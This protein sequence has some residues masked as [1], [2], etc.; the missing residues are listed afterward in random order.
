MLVKNK[1][2]PDTL[3]AKPDVS[4]KEHL[5]EVYNKVKEISRYLK[6]S[7]DLYKKTLLA[8]ILH[9]IGKATISFQSY[10]RKQSKDSYP[11]ALASFPFVLLL[12][13]E[14]TMNAEF[15]EATAAVLTHHSP[16]TFKLYKGYGKPDY[17]LDKLR[18]LLVHILSFLETELDS[19][20]SP[21]LLEKLI[22][23]I[24]NE[25]TGLLDRSWSKNGHSISLRGHLQN[26]DTEKFA[27]VK[28]VLHL[29]DWIVSSGKSDLNKIFLI[30]GS[31]W[32]EKALSRYELRDFQKRSSEHTGSKVL[33]LRAPTGSGKTEALLL[34]ARHAMRI[35]YFLP[36][37]AT[38][39]AMWDRLRMIFPSEYVGISHGNANYI[40]NSHDESS[41][42]MRLFSSAFA[43]PVVVATL[44]QYLFAH[45]HGKYWE[46]KLTLSKQ[47][48][49]ILD[50]IHA[51]EPYTIGLL[52][53]A[54][55]KVPPAYYALA[56]ATLPESLLK[57]FPHNKEAVRIEAD[58]SIWE[59]KRHR[60]YL[61][62][63][64]NIIEDGVNLAIKHANMGKK[65]LV[66]LNT[67]QQAQNFYNILRKKCE[68]KGIGTT[69][70]HSRFILR[71]RYK[72]EK[73]I[74]TVKAPF[75]LVA[76]QVVEVSL[77]ISYDI[78]ITEIAP[79][80]AIIQRMGRIN[81]RGDL[82]PSSVFIYTKPTKNSIKVY[83]ENILL[84]SR[85]LLEKLPEV[86]DNRNLAD[87]TEILYQDIINSPDWQKEFERGKKTVDEIQKVLGCYTIDLTDEEMTELFKTRSGAPSIEVLPD[88]FSNQA[89]E[90]KI[91]KELWRLPEL[92]VPV[93]VWWK[94]KLPNAFTPIPDIGVFKTSLYYD[95]EMGLQFNEDEHF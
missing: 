24:Q 1:L 19:K 25:P 9:D 26:L 62:K 20:L 7:D 36:T 69:L 8:A 46:D 67:I 35:L 90:L 30:E 42:D 63:D 66:V 39:N 28:T 56:S 29:A 44:D 82:P 27:S 32:V 95:S 64:G 2:F 3:L 84:K 77:D 45:L 37:Q 53:R 78:L 70:L 4:L 33:Y 23:F 55:E 74:K 34:W 14:M 72:K 58:S 11:H 81:R 10:I 71:D 15:G 57:Y 49:V 50:E 31:Q 13:I 93:P 38:T 75:I 47:A 76:T 65:V 6:L 52:V 83:G 61:Q 40:L 86:P 73:L 16:L 79:L 17:D 51:Y 59:K 43:K 41:L 89:E 68:G 21:K 91:K 80:D 60:L 22:S 88:I 85:E 5:F 54:L 12:E 48:A 92:L 87:F 94:K 18:V